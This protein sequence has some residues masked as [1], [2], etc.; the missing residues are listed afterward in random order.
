MDIALD[1]D[2]TFTLDPPMWSRFVG[3]AKELG[4][5]IR[6]VTMR[7]PSESESIATHAETLGIEIIYTSRQGKLNYCYA[8]G[9]RPHIWIDDAPHWVLSDAA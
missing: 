5:D 2:G 6:F 7:Y 8:Q 4:H 9:F 3:H 1:F